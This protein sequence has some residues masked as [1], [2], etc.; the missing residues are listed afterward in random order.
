VKIHARYLK[1]PVSNFGAQIFL[2]MVFALQSCGDDN[3]DP[4]HSYDYYPVKVGQFSIFEI[5]QVIYSLGQKDSVVTKWQEKDEV[6]KLLKIDG[7]V[8]TFI[9]SRFTRNSSSDTWQKVKEF[10]IQ[11]FPD[12]ILET[13]DNEINVPMFF[14][15]TSNLEW[16]GYMYF[17][18][19]ENDYRYG[20]KNSYQNVNKPLAVGAI[21]FGNTLMVKE[22]FDTSKTEYKVAQKYYAIN[23]GLI[24]SEQADFE[25]LQNNGELI[26]N[27][28]IA[29]GTR[30][31]RR[32]IAYGQ[33][34]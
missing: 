4:I 25:Y 7:D 22:R 2:L 9:L 33:N 14:P 24:S 8:S 12:K 11:K 29:S 6:T 19:N 28:V 16:D 1:A 20:Y 32:I 10:S 21:S 27:K 5:N 18:L 23:V 26:G 31:I 30:K 13:L 17:N 34:N 3:V 15:V